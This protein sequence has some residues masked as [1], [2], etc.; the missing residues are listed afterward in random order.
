M[1]QLL[2]VLLVLP[3]FGLWCQTLER[4][5]VGAAGGRVQADAGTLDWTAGETRVNACN[6][7]NLY[8]GEGFQQVW[9]APLVDTGDPAADPAPAFTVYPNPAADYLF[10]ATGR[11]QLHAQLFDLAGRPVTD[12]ISVNDRASIGLAA[13]PAGFYLLRALDEAGRL[14]G[15]TKVQVIH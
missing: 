11:M 2:I 4:Q 3:A 13:L 1:K 14:L 8:W 15:A 10:V 6:H 9:Y 12:L 7:P 5:V